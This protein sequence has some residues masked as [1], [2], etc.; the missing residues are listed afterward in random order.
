MEVQLAMHMKLTWRLM[1]MDSLWSRFFLAKYVKQGHVS[2]VSR[3]ANGS[4]LWR[5]I[6]SVIPEVCEQ[7]KYNVQ[8]G[9]LSFWFDR[10]FLPS[11]LSETIQIVVNLN[12]LI[13]EVWI[14]EWNME[15][16]V[17]LVGEEIV[18]D[19]LRNIHFDRNGNGCFDL[20]GYQGWFFF[21]G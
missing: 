5:S 7:I 15:M 13:K 16:L 4:W 12:L 6:I 1:S 21:Y 11:P 3:P 14:N 18:E 19:V 9:H 17:Q 10:W 8:E 20:E 2:L